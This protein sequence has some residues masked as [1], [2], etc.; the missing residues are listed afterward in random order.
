[1][2]SLWVLL[3]VSGAAMADDAAMLRCR[4]LTDGPA[5]LSCYDAIPLGGPAS[6][7]APGA[8]AIVAS[9]APSYAPTKADLERGFGN[10]H[11]S[12]A[13]KLEFIETS[14]V[15]EFDGWV[16]KQRIRLAN[17]QVWMIADDSQANLDL[18]NPKV[19]LEKGML[20]VIYMDIEG[21]STAPRV[22]RVK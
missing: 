22:K 10:E 6:A 2:K 21:A 11:N 8:P 5:R 18:V 13:A 20:G 1:M 15:G 17:G 12:P 7:A 19:R 4:Q 9:A 14:I 3:F 16:P